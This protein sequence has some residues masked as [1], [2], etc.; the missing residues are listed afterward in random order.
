[1]LDQGLARELIKTTSWKIYWN[2]P[3][4]ELFKWMT[5]SQHEDGWVIWS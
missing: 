2:P 1:M 4:P 5:L 3:E